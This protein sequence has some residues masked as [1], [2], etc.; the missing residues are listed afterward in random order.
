MTHVETP[1][2]NTVCAFF[3]QRKA[4][5]SAA[6]LI[7]AW[8]ILYGPV[9]L[10]FS[11]TA[12]RRDENSHIIFIMGIIIATASVRLQIGGFT[13]PSKF[14]TAAGAAILTLGLCAYLLGRAG[15]AD[16][17][18]SASQIFVAVGGGLV[19]IGAAGLRRLWF[20]LCLMA[21]LIIWPGW[22]IDSV[23]A[24]LKRLVSLLVSDG[25]YAAGMPVAHEGAV[26]SAGSYELLVA[27]ACAG[28]NSL[29]AL[30]AVGAVYLYAVK[31]RSWK[32]N[33]AVALSLVPLAIIANIVRVAILV[34]ITYYLGYDAGQSFLHEGAGLVMFAAALAGVFLV[35]QLAARWWEPQP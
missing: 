3:E 21:Y 13:K 32:T 30:T 11:Q 19:L 28:L 24:P 23:T 29:F 18:L 35:D 33:L 26:I 34:L 17:I 20:P 31:R 7:V 2:L 4:A 8:L 5:V 6:V 14:E 22:A 25:L 15:E 9:Y 10:E 16:I 12:W 27:D 1:F